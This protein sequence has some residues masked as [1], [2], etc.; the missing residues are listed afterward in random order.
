MRKVKP[1]LRWTQTG[2]GPTEGAK[3]EQELKEPVRSCQ[4]GWRQNGRKSECVKRGD[5]DIELNDGEESEPS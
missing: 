4:G 1:E 5:L 3:R 2:N